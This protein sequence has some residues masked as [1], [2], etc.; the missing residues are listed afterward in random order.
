MEFLCQF[1]QQIETFFAT[2]TITSGYDNRRTFQVV[3]SLLNVTVYNLYHIISFRYI[4]GNISN[5]NLTIVISIE[6]FLFHHTLTDSSHL[7]AV[8]RIHNSCNDVTT[9]SRTD[10][11]EQLVVVLTKF[12]IIMFTDFELCTVGSQTTLQ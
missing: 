12:L 3:L 7:W 9:E 11:I 10:L 1:I 4:F 6:N 8:F 5:D 2:H